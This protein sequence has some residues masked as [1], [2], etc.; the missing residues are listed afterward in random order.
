[1]QA[2][3]FHG[4][5]KMFHLSIGTVRRLFAHRATDLF[6]SAEDFGKRCVEM[7]F[8]TIDKRRSDCVTLEF[9]LDSGNE[10]LMPEVSYGFIND[11]C[12]PRVGCRNRNV[13]SK[14][15]SF[16]PRSRLVEGIAG[17]L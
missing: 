15:D 16:E 7:A 5:T 3:A 6:L 17:E 9:L 8:G 4:M 1:M 13:I 14:P 2:S 10:P 12:D 11:A